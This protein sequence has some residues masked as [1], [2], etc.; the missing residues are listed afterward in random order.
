MNSAELIKNLRDEAD[1]C[2]N[3]TATDIADLLDDAAS[4]LIA[5]GALFS[6]LK[7]ERNGLAARVRELE[8]DASKQE[9]RKMP[10]FYAPGTK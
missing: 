8:G 5:T 6:A 3:E 2:R 9:S 10:V 1:L 7:D 4:A